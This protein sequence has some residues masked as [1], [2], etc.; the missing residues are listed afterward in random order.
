MSLLHHHLDR[1]AAAAPQRTVIESEG[2]SLTLSQLRSA[3][4]ELAN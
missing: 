1:A 3:A 4:Y 2:R